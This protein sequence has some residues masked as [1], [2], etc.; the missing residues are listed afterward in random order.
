VD[1][2]PPAPQ[3]DAPAPGAPLAGAA[4]PDSAWLRRLTTDLTRELE[5]PLGRPAATTR[6]EAAANATQALTLWRSSGLAE[7]AFADLMQAARR[8]TQAAK[9]HQRDGGLRRPMAYFFTVLADLV[10]ADRGP[11]NAEVDLNPG[12]PR[13]REQWTEAAGEPP[14]VDLGAPSIPRSAFR[15]P[16]SAV[17]PSAFPLPTSAA[18]PYSPYIAGVMLDYG[19]ELGAGPAGCAHVTQALRLWEQSGLGATPFVGL[20][21]AAR[22]QVRGSTLPSGAR[23]NTLPQFFTVLQAL[24]AQ[25]AMTPAEGGR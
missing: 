20:L 8:R 22:R 11:R 2:I 21:H 10:N 15:N 23:L 13:R 1:G 5:A 3:D 25:T 14:Q 12:W 9:G 16:T 24:L 7:A 6:T 18:P 4:P 19:R 17:P